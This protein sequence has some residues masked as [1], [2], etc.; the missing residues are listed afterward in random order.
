MPKDYGSF[1]RLMKLFCELYDVLYLNKLNRSRC[2]LYVFEC[3]NGFCGFKMVSGFWLPCNNK[4]ARKISGLGHVHKATNSLFSFF[5]ILL[6][7]VMFRHSCSFICMVQA[8]VSQFVAKISFISTTHFYL[9]FQNFFFYFSR[10]LPSDFHITSFLSWFE[11][12]AQCCQRYQPCN[13]SGYAKHLSR[14]YYQLQISLSSYLVRLRH[15]P[16]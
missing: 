2:I 16:A 7:T 4:H 1:C 5:G 10:F 3:P 6:L 15:W 12:F 8:G 9:L 11:L 14:H 13:S